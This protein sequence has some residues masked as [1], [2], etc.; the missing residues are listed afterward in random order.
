MTLAL[1]ILGAVCIGSLL[2]NGLFLCLAAKVLKVASLS[3]RRAL[4]I[5]VPMIL[6]S[7]AIAIPLELLF[8]TA[9]LAGNLALLPL[10]LA[11]SIGL[12][13]LFLRATWL[14]ALGVWLV[15]QVFA[16]VY[17]VVL[18]LIL[19]SAVME[20]FVVPTGAM[21]EA[22]LGY[23]KEIECPQC[24]YRFLLNASMEAD[25]TARH[26]AERCTCAN[27]YADIEFR[28]ARINPPLLSGDRLLMLRYPLS[29]TPE[30]LSLVIFTF[31]EEQRDGQKYLYVKRL[32]GLPGETIAIH[33]GDLYVGRGI[34]YDHRPEPSTEEARR[35]SGMHDNDERALAAFQDQVKERFAPRETGFEI[36][37]KSPEQILALRRLVHDN[38]FQP[39]QQK[40][41]RWTNEAKSNWCGDHPSTS[42]AF[43]S[44]SEERGWLCYR[45]FGSGASE[46]PE[47][48]R[49]FF[50]YNASSMFGSENWV[51]DLILE[52]DVAVEEPTGEFAL[53][54]AHGVDRFQAR[55]ALASGECTFTRHREAGKIEETLGKQPTA[56]NQR[57]TYR[58]RFANVD[59]RLSVWVNDQLPFGGGVSYQPPAE[60]GPTE[61]D[62][63]PARIGAFGCGVTVSHL[64]LWRDTYYTAALMSPADGD[65]GS[66]PEWG[67]T[68]DA[69]SDP[70]RWEPLRN[71]PVRAFY[72]QPGH[73]F[74]L[75]D[76][77]SNSSDSRFWGLVPERLLHGRVVM[78]YYP[79]SRVGP[80]P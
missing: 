20:A 12:L 35:K 67:H 73:Y 38:D 5:S 56:M 1:I 21:A 63:Q 79:F 33:Y 70:S 71:L 13:H 17:T 28:A 78:I 42:R 46:K 61:H 26:V 69:W 25:P 60:R 72:V 52:C 36:M 37:R 29:G 76:N 24:K 30:R 55:W 50:G 74:F 11:I 31:P 22:V 75:G 32:I 9:S 58:L 14:K 64:R 77:S 80:V 66:G 3:Y 16:I 39:A 7:M 54:L 4:L 8:R 34:S 44:N 10:N 65:A 59:R 49:D 68:S 53:D 2:T 51:G 19:K 47:L 62:L 6:I 18:V 43:T 27:C 41:S 40:T 23:H 15:W 57:G 48:I 45:H